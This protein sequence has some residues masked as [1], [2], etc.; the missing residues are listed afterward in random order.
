MSS[1]K[2]NHRTTVVRWICALPAA[3]FAKWLC[4]G[5]GGFLLS[6]AGIEIRGT[7][8]P[9][10]LFPLLQT[11]PVGVAFT[12]VGAFVAPDGKTVTATV[13]TGFLILMSVTIHV[14]G[15]S[16]PGLTNYMHVT[17]ESLGAIIGVVVVF[18]RRGQD[19]SANA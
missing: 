14:F 1:E 15:Q 2:R 17:G 11:L 5:I 8:Y 3:Y 9:A 16:N 4:G 19:S 13:L 12:L 6:S 18:G 10:F 7:G